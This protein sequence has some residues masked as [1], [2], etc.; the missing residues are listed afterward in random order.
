MDVDAYMVLLV[1]GGN[2]VWTDS[3]RLANMHLNTEDV[4][5]ETVYVDGGEYLSAAGGWLKRWRHI[6]QIDGL[7]NL[8]EGFCDMPWV[9]FREEVDYQKRVTAMSHDFVAEKV[10]SKMSLDLIC[11]DHPFKNPGVS[12]AIIISTST[13]KR[14]RDFGG[15]R[16]WEIC[17]LSGRAWRSSR[18]RV[19]DV[20]S[21]M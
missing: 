3:G 5:Y 2:V 14:R 20:P 18:L 7:S 13:W 15:I 6:D 17:S 11:F 21:I 12:L 8:T 1:P 9:R 4:N 16:I 10:V 19:P